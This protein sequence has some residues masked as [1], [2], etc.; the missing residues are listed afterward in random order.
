MPAL[1][2]RASKTIARPQPNGKRAKHPKTKTRKGGLG[3]TCRAQPG[4]PQGC[5]ET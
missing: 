2:G 1:A 3:A 4:I 5:Q